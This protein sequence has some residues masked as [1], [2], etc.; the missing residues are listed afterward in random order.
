MNIL[1][2][3]SIIIDALRQNQSLPS[4]H[5]Y[6]ISDITITEL[7][8]GKSIWESKKKKGI[9]DNVLIQLTHLPTSTTLCQLAGKIRAA[10]YTSVPDAIIAATAIENKLSL[11]TLNTKDFSPIPH[12]KLI[13]I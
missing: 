13:K 11:A 8:S 4:S 10:Y 6:Y 12:L 5:H 9:L 7:Y 2:D 1:L 3:S